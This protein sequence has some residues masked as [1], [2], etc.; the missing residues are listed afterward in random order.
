MAP[1]YTTSLGEPPTGACGCPTVWALWHAVHRTRPTGSISGTGKGVTGER[2]RKD[3]PMGAGSVPWVS[4]AIVE[5]A[6]SPEKRC[7]DSPRRTFGVV[8][9]GI[10]LPRQLSFG[11]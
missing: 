7:R 5:A 2:R 10:G 8:R 4:I 11:L 1:E 6:A 9:R 3:V